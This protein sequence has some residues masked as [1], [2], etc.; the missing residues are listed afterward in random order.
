MEHGLAPDLADDGDGEYVP[1][2]P[3]PLSYAE[4]PEVGSRRPFP[5]VARLWSLLAATPTLALPARRRRAVRRLARLSRP[6]RPLAKTRHPFFAVDC[7][8]RDPGAVFLS[9]RPRTHDA[10][11]LLRL[12]RLAPHLVLG[13]VRRR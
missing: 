7:H 3:E 10:R 11:G 4:L 13:R 6:R 9:L 5:W 12:V 8:R 1:P 2:T